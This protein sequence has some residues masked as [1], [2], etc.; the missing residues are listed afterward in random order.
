MIDMTVLHQKYRYTSPN[1]PT[2]N[3]DFTIFSEDD[4]YFYLVVDLKIFKTKKSSFDS[5]SVTE[6]GD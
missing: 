2:H 4:K 3:F 1:T 5:L 6:I